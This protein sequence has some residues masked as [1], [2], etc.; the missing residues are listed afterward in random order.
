MRLFWREDGDRSMLVKDCLCMH[1]G[2]GMQHGPHRF[3]NELKR[4]EQLSICEMEVA[5]AAP[6]APMLS[7]Y[8]K[9]TSIRRLLRLASTTAY[10]GVLASLSPRQHPM[11]TKLSS[12]KGLPMHRPYM[13]WHA[14]PSITGS[15]PTTAHSIQSVARDKLRVLSSHIYTNI[16]RQLLQYT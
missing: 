15:P 3:I 12:T 14:W 8:T 10:S 13:Y 6:A 2:R 5:R 11:N 16:C 7:P 1:E 4:M 9:S